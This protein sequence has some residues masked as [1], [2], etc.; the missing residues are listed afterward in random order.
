MGEAREGDLT[1]GDY[2]V[3]LPDGRTQV[4]EYRVEGGDTGYIVS[5][6]YEGDPKE[7]APDDPSSVRKREI[8]RRQKLW[9]PYAREKSE[10]KSSE[11]SKSAV[12]IISASEI[13]KAETSSSP[14][15]MA[16]ASSQLSEAKSIEPIPDLLLTTGIPQ[17]VKDSISEPEV[18]PRIVNLGPTNGGIIIPTTEKLVEAS[19]TGEE[20]WAPK[21]REGLTHL[22]YNHIA[23]S[24]SVL[25]DEPTTVLESTTTPSTTA[26]LLKND[27]SAEK[28]ETNVDEKP[29][30]ERLGSQAPSMAV[31]ETPGE[32]HHQWFSPSKVIQDQRLP[33]A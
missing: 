19:Y 8:V 27:H 24:T 33:F 31:L 18:K 7:K 4:V 14:V 12:K 22:D 2:R 3:L 25:P 11:I 13:E 28:E 5:V 32:D 17:P 30:T 21:R 16:S 15:I 20:E 6:K 23:P 1:S 9:K 26:S 29:S 10:V